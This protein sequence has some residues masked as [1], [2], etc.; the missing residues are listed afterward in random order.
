MKHASSVLPCPFF[1]QISSFSV[2]A[3]L[4]TRSRQFFVWYLNCGLPLP[5]FVL[6][7][8]VTGCNPT[9]SAHFLLTSGCA[10]VPLILERSLVSCLHAVF[11]QWCSFLLTFWRFCTHILWWS[12]CRST[13]PYL[14]WGQSRQTH[15]SFLSQF[16]HVRVP[17]RHNRSKRGIV[18][19]FYPLYRNAANAGLISVLWGSLRFSPWFSQWYFFTIKVQKIAHLTNFYYHLFYWFSNSYIKMNLSYHV[20]INS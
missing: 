9:P 11:S 4:K 14:Q 13:S 8:L 19:W 16:F 3:I 18:L 12:G 15:D 6:S 1:C 10:P 2:L 17:V 7:C 5:T 20:S